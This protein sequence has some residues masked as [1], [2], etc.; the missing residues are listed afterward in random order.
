VSLV[1]L[2]FHLIGQRKVKDE[3]INIGIG[4]SL[5]GDYFGVLQRTRNL[6]DHMFSLIYCGFQV[7]LDINE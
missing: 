6:E 1:S 7:R 5:N 2:P 3:S 4:A